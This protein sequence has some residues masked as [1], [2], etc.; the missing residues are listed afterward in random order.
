MKNIQQNGN[1][2]KPSV[3]NT[4]KGNPKWLDHYKSR[5][6]SRISAILDRRSTIFHLNLKFLKQSNMT[7]KEK[8]NKEYIEAFKAKNTVA[9]NLLSVIK[10]EIQTIE[11][12]T[13]VENLS[14]EDVTKILNKTVKSLKETLKSLTESEKIASVQ[15]E[16]NI[17]ESYLP[18]QLSVEEI[19]SKIDALVISGVKNL[20]M[21]M[22]E[23]NSL[24]VDK[25]LVSE[26]VKKSVI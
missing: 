1:T 4:L 2:A 9:K 21:I 10:G 15:T 16:L 5:L 8:I 7:L 26:M 11:K 25:K 22:K 20:G 6:G 13:S 23:F 17:V 3:I 24:P 14:D 18:K 19:Q 12:N